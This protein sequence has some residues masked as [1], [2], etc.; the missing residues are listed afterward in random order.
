MFDLLRKLYK[1]KNFVSI[2]SNLE[3]TEKFIYGKILCV[4]ED[5]ILIYMLSPNGNYDGMLVQQ[6][7]NIFRIEYGGEYE[8]KMK[9]LSS[10]YDLPDFDFPADESNI[11]LSMLRNVLNN[12]K[13]VSIE[14]LSSGIYD[15]VGI[16]EKIDETTCK[17]KQY[18][19]YGFEDGY[20]IINL[21]DITK[22]CCDSEEELRIERLICKHY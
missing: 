11:G 21:D 12:K 4:N 9:L 8:S 18:N 20:S 22:I 3:E 13:M 1:T 10:N 15:I 6:T 7:P 19:D 17:I 5:E 2:Y 14:L 16:V